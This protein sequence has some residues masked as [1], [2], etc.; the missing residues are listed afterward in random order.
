VEDAKAA[1]PLLIAQGNC[2]RNKSRHRRKRWIS[3]FVVRAAKNAGLAI[4]GKG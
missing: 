3:D 1:A 2:P 4:S